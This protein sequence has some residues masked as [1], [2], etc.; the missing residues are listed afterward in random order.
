[1]INHNF[2]IYEKIPPFLM[3]NVNFFPWNVVNTAKSVFR[4]KLLV[5]FIIFWGQKIFLLGLFSSK[6]NR[7]VIIYNKTLKSLIA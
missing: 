2:F 1:M 3:P 4:S 6:Y 5:V 7:M